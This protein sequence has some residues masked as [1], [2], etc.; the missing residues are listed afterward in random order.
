MLLNEYAFQ[1]C[2]NESS[3]SGWLHDSVNLCNTTELY[4]CKWLGGSLRKEVDVEKNH[5][6]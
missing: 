1:S 6:E 2:K 4:T 3:S 5:L